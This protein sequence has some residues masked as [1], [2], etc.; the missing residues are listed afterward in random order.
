M[1]HQDLTPLVFELRSCFLQLSQILPPC[2]REG[3]FSSIHGKIFLYKCPGLLDGL[4]HTFAHYTC[5]II[6]IIK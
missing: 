3:N 6:G 1:I 4:Q 2:V 5:F